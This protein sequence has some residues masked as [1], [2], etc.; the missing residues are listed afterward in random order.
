M[1]RSNYKTTLKTLIRD[2]AV[3]IAIVAVVLM[4]VTQGKWQNGYGVVHTERDLLMQNIFNMVRISTWCGLFPAFL[5]VMI[6]SNL[7]SERKNNFCDILTTSNTSFR[8]FF[9]SKT[10]ALWTVATAAH[11]VYLLLFSLHYW[12]IQAPQVEVIFREVAVHYLFM[13][14][15]YFLPSLLVAT[16]IG[17]IGVSITGV[18]PI[19]AFVSLAY[20]FLL[21]IFP[22][23]HMPNSVWGGILY[24]LPMQYECYMI[25]FSYFN[26]L[27]PEIDRYAAMNYLLEK[28][29]K[30]TGYLVTPEKA[31]LSIVFHCVFSVT[32]LVISYFLLKKRYNRNI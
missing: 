9:F 3:I 32:L 30:N 20:V 6:S 8:K 5:G 31:L 1:F 18:Q 28:M 15:A 27:N 10:L 14:A 2:P 25:Q 24:Y 7:L 11:I 29:L 4:V 16:A 21:N 26:Y 22:V 23:L 13:E 12:I 19:G 17:Y